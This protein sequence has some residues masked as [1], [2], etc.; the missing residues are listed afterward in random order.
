MSSIGKL[1]QCPLF[2][3]HKCG[4]KL[5]GEQERA[6]RKV[7]RALGEENQYLRVPRSTKIWNELGIYLIDDRHNLVV[8]H[9]TIE[10]LLEEL[11]SD[12]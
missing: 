4:E 2:P 3:P 10:G 12:S 6:L 1:T 8:G 7:R 9:C 11:K 5:R